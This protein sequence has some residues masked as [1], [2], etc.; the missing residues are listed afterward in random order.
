MEMKSKGVAIIT[1]A[2]SGIGKG[3]A[4]FLAEENYKLV[5]IARDQLRLEQLKN[6]IQKQKASCL[7]ELV[8]LDVSVHSDVEK[9]FSSLID[10]YE[11]IDMLVNSAGYVK[12]GSSELPYEELEK[13]LRVNLLGLFDVTKLVAA[14]MKKQRSG[15]IINISSISGLE[16]RKELAGYSASKY[17]LMGLNDALAKELIDYNVLVTAICPNLVST[18]MTEDVKSIHQ[19]ELVPVSDVVK[20]VGYLLSLS[21][22]S[23]IKEIVIRCKSAYQLR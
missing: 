10:R 18:K 6:Q 1:G 22:N 3:I 17:G 7:I 12:R 14:K 15:R 11:T 2:S 4:K 21:G 13:M 19:D 23:Y 20:A 9:V 16:A 5:L 8:S